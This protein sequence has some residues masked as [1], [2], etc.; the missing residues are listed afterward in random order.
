M[1]RKYF[2]ITDHPLGKGGKNYWD[3]GTMA[4]MQEHFRWS[5]ETPGIGLIT[6][7]PGVGKTVL[8]RHL[9]APLNPHRYK[10]IYTPETDFGRLDLY[11]NLAFAMGLEP[12]YRRAALWRELKM[13][14]Q[15]MVQGSQCQPIWI[16]DEAQNLPTEFFLDLPAFLNFAFDSLDLITIWLVGH[17][18][19]ASTLERAPYKAL[20]SRIQTR[21]QLKPIIKREAFNQLIDFALKEVGCQHPVLSES[22]M[23]L[24]RQGSRGLPRTASTILITAMRHAAAQ[25]NNHIPDDLLKQVIEELQ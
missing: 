12:P 13:H 11:R 16:I 19:L 9:T 1:Y 25:N 7:E 23:E 24:L 15:Q 14:I 5:L 17:P 3:D 21:I 4:S 22:G 6:G 2:G 10:I 18:A 20:N 8:V